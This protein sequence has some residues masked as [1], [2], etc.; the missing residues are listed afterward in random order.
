MD[1]ITAAFQDNRTLKPWEPDPAWSNEERIKQFGSWLYAAAI[2][3]RNMTE[4]IRRESARGVIQMSPGPE[5]SP[6]T[7]DQT[8]GFHLGAETN[9]QNACAAGLF[10]AAGCL[11]GA[12]GLGKENAQPDPTPWLVLIVPAES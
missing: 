3:L 5:K 9:H 12:N 10:S 11:Y 6:R 8:T 2:A 4:T 1:Q 7:V